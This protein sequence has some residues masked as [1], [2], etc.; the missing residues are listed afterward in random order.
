MPLR[1]C[2]NGQAFIPESEL[3]YFKSEE[4]QEINRHYA[5]EAEKNFKADCTITRLP[6]SLKEKLK[7]MEINTGKKLMVSSSGKATLPP[8]LLQN[9]TDEEISTLNSYCINR[10]AAQK[11]EKAIESNV[12]ELPEP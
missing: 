7:N 4:L 12:K 11:R 5:K 8:E 9:F 3:K 6:M 2:P 1:I 10:T